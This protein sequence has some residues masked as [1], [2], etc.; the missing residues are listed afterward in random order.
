VAVDRNPFEYVRPLPP[1]EVQGRD[2]L[3]HELLTAVGERRLVAVAGPRRYGKTSLLGRVAALA[4]EVGLVDVVRIDCFG[5]ASAGEFAV[6]LER[7]LA[8]LSGPTRRIARRLL[9]GGEL[10]LSVA[11]GLGF[12]AR[13]GRPGAPDA[14]AV[15]HELLGTV[16]SLSERRSGLLLILDE[17]QDVGRIG[18]LDAVLRAHLQHARQ[19]AVLFAGSRP[20]LLRALFSDRARPFY[21]QAQIVE[22]GR[23][24][25]A[26]AA[27]I[28]EDGFERTARD[29]GDTGELVASLTG[30]HPQRLM[31]MAH[32][33]WDRVEPGGT[34]SGEDLGAALEVA[35]DRTDAEH[36]AVIEGLDRT[37]R[38]TLRAIAAYGAPYARTAERALGLGQGTARNAVR[39]LEVDALIERDADGRWHLVD[40]LLADWLTRNL[41]LPPT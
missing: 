33:L 12:K 22:I 21:G 37:H 20:S 9:E 26:A 1:G 5:V 29:A 39:A 16:V 14:T 27:R 40:P 25:H 24:D 28:V 2:A 8:E 4:G 3:C 11:P 32:L 34:A 38:T 35:R 36:R 31:L 10:G 30:G 13:F 23:L 15:L 6:R 7:A 41:P 18:G 17:F 19:L